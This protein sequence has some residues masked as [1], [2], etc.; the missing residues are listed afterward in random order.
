MDRYNEMNKHIACVETFF[1]V[2]S[3]IS[4]HGLLEEVKNSSVS[5]LLMEMGERLEAI[6]KLNKETND[7]L[8]ELKNLTGVT[9]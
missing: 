4:K 7:R 6:K 3:V 1:D 9:G 8:Q 5:Y 2:F